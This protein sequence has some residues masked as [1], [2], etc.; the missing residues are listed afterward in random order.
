MNFQLISATG[1]KFDQPAYEI[2]VPTKDGAI[3]LYE[4]HMPLI[5]SG[6]PGVLSIRKK[7]TD[8]DSEM[9]HFAIYGGIMQVDGKSARFVTDDVTTTDEVSETEA[10]AAL[11]RAQDLVAGAE[12]RVALHEAR[13]MILH[14]QARLHLA[15][16]KNRHHR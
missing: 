12:S 16:I 6:A 14:H 7:Q 8:K 13:T 1:I 9:E 11:E 15:Q 5:S 2:I 10:K 4:D 3:A